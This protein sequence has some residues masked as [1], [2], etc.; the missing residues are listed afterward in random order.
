MN[1]VTMKLVWHDCVTYPPEEESN[2]NL[3]M[4]D[5]KTVWNVEYERID[6]DGEWFKDGT[7][8]INVNLPGKKYMW[9]DLLQTT[10]GFFGKK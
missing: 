1:K 8:S 2:E 6:G 9:A 3:I 7:H 5:G 4:T 10:Q